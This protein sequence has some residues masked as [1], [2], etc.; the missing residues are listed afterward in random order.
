LRRGLAAFSKGLPP[1]STTYHQFV[2]RVD[3][4]GGFVMVEPDNPADLA[5]TTKQS[6]TILD[7]RICPVV[8]IAR[9]APVPKQDV[10]LGDA[11]G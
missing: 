8:D 9:A 4:G 10:G 2:D 7:Y 11:V 3:G 1:Q 5:D 6:A